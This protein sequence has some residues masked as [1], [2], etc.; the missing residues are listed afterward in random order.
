MVH[1]RQQCHNSKLVI[2]Q[3]KLLKVLKRYAFL[4]AQR[5]HNCFPAASFTNCIMTLYLLEVHLQSF[6]SIPITQKCQILICDT[7]VENERYVLRRWVQVSG[8]HTVNTS[9]LH[10]RWVQRTIIWKQMCISRAVVCIQLI[11]KKYFQD[12]RW[13]YSHSSRDIAWALRQSFHSR[14]YGTFID[15]LYS[16]WASCIHFR[17]CCILCHEDATTLLE[18]LQRLE[19]VD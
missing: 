6:L 3:E 5:R 12:P 18:T 9:C 13:G 10:A 7:F 2:F 14:I 8:N 15:C 16:P 4:W 11:V 19:D 17:I 1:L